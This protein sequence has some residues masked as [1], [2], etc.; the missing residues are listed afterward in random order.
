MKVENSG[1]SFAGIF[2]DLDLLKGSDK[3]RLLKGW[4][5]D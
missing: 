1:R 2:A 4:G 5:D 3:V